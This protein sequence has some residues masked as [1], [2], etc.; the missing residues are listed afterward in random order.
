MVVSHHPVVAD[1]PLALQPEHLPQL[2]RAR[3][4]PVIILRLRCRAP[5][6]PVVLRQ[7]FLL[8]ILVRLLVRANPLPSH[9][10]D[11]PVLMRPVVA[12]H[13][14]LRLRRS[15][16]DDRD[17]QLL[18]HPPKL[19]HRLFPTQL[20]P[21]CGR[22]F[23]QVFP[24]HVQPL[25]H[26]VLFNPPLQ[27]VGRRP[28]RLLLAQ[29]QLHRAGRIV[30]HVHH[31]APRTAPLQPVVKTPV[32]LHQ[33]PK[34]PPSLPPLPIRFPLAPPAPQPLRQHPP[35]QRL[36]VD[37]HPV[38][39]RQMF[40]RQRRPKPLSLALPILL[41]HQLHHPPPKSLWLGSRARPSRI[42]M[43]QPLGP[44]LPIP[45][46]QP[47]RLPVTHPNQARRIHHLQLFAL[48]SRQHFDPA[49]FSLAHPYSPHP[50]SFRGRSL[51]DLSI[52]EKRG[53][54]HRGSTCATSSTATLACA[55]FATVVE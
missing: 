17:P 53:H 7:I 50:A 33:L 21:L 46:P 48:H 38:F 40:G 22:A 39:A 28:D 42:A 14:P 55:G 6:T 15:R 13:S 47:L 32:H 5:E 3:C 34:V 49:Q 35:P 26:S 25:R 52:E 10:L 11:Q 20:F 2:P 44:F 16:R 8:Q 29:P 24:V 12:L 30:G 51:G 4:P 54:Y 27:R 19:R 37:P 45:L 43:L 41:P 36:R 23:I 9:L 18:A 1:D 31:A